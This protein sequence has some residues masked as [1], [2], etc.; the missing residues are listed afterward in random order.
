MAHRITRRPLDILLV[1]L[2]I[3]GLLTGC[4]GIA[5]GGTQPVA[6]GPDHVITLDGTEYRIPVALL[7][8]TLTDTPSPVQPSAAP[9]QPV[10]PNVWLDPALPEQFVEQIDL[11]DGWQR[12]AEYDQANLWIDIPVQEYRSGT[13]DLNGALVTT[14][15]YAVVAPFPTV[16][17][18][19]SGQLIRQAWEGQL[20]RAPGKQ[21][22]WMT[23]ETQAVLEAAWGPA[24]PKGVKVIAEADL[25]GAAWK[26]QDSWAI[27]PFEQIEPRWKVLRVDGQSPLDTAFVPA[28]YPLGISITVTGQAEAVEIIPDPMP[29]PT[30]RDPE[31]MTTLVMTGVTAL[32]RHIAEQMESKGV[33][34]PGTRIRDWLVEADLTHVSNEVSF[35]AECPKPGPERADMRF[36]SHPKY[37]ELLEYIGA[38]IIELTGN[39]NLDWGPQP[40]L[41]TLELYRQRG[42][43]T[44]GGGA[45]LEAARQP[46]YIEHNG[47][48]LVFLGCSPAGPDKVWATEYLPG[49]APCNLYKLEAQIRQLR[50]QG[51]LPVVTLQ[52]VETDVYLPPPA[53]GAP[54][55]RRLARAGAIIV[56]GSQ[57]HVPQTMTF[58]PAETGGDSFVHYGLGNLFFDQVEPKESRQQFIDR[59]VIYD[60]RYLGVDLLTAVL[61]DNL[62]PRPMTR[63]E[64]E[65]FLEAIFSLSQWDEP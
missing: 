13:D 24:S 1:A 16:L 26:A 28:K 25:L 42:W 27:V 7:D 33:T 3:T 43:G 59:H 31:K 52:A 10:R 2:V 36:C 60:G 4:A 47:N 19:V 56:S 32:S 45:N 21:P 55:F 58:V 37:I 65:E 29:L 40:F 20:A 14:W 6:T 9:A 61:E 38:D 5:A 30:N 35:Y 11:P 50:S 57:S 15:V 51:Y 53:Q 41:D 63:A 18:E 48:R 22:L 34:Y 39:H 54:D 44:Y 23:A 64:R 46:L 8:D 49:S 62:R 17:D 12:V